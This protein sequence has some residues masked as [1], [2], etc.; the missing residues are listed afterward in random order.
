M[1]SSARRCTS[2]RMWPYRFAFRTAVLADQPR[3]C[4][5]TAK[6]SI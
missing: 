4:A 1:P 5:T 6:A 3:I 2:D